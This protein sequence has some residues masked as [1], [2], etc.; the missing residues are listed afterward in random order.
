MINDYKKLQG[1]EFA[2]RET[3]FE[4]FGKWTNA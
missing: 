2:M 3:S 1:S 4:V